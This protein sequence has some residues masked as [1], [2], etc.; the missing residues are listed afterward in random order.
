S[1]NPYPGPQSSSRQPYGNQPAYNQYPAPP[2][3]WQPPPPGVGDFARGPP[4]PP[5]PGMQGS[6]VPGRMSQMVAPNVQYGQQQSAAPNYPPYDN[7]RSNESRGNVGRPR[8]NYR[9]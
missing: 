5:P 8:D 2:H 6:Y 3:G 7:S 1:S 4:P 9:Y